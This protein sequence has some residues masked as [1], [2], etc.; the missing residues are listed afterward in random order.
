MGL[1]AGAS[2]ESGGVFSSS[3]ESSDAELSSQ[4]ATEAEEAEEHGLRCLE[5]AR[6]EQRMPAPVKMAPF[7]TP[8]CLFPEGGEQML[9]FA[10]PSKQGALM[11]TLDGTLPCYHHL[12][13]STPTPSHMRNAGD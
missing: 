13:A 10:P 1:L 5:L 9:S 2:S 6:T 7:F 12:S 8:N 11:L 4:R 3:M